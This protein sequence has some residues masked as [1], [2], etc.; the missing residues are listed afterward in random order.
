MTNNKR[1]RVKLIGADGNAF[2]IMG[3]CKQA[4]R[5]AGWTREQIDALIKEMMSGDYNHLLGVAM[6]KFEVS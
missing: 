6:E 4:A 1:P 2:A 3:A 5:K